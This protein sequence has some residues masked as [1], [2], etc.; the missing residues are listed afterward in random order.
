MLS[1]A[2]ND[3]DLLAVFAQGIELVC[4][5]SLQLL[6][7]NVGKLSFGDQRF[8]LGADKLL[9]KNNNLGGVWLLVLQLSNLIGD[10][11]L[12]YGDISV[13]YRAK[14]GYLRSRLGCTD[15]SMFRMLL[16]VTRYWS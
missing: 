8:S 13:G 2:G 16:M 6:A 4:E 15:A 14:S 3:S 5:S 11:L 12:S 7:G 1:E 10:L 9:L